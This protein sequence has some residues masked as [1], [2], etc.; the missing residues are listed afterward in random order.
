MTNKKEVNT[1][2]GSYIDGK[3][4]IGGDYVGEDKYQVTINM[5]SD[6]TLTSILGNLLPSQ[7]KAPNKQEIFKH[8]IEP[9]FFK[10]E[11]VHKDYTMML[12]E[13]KRQIN[14]NNIDQQSLID[15]VEARMIIFESER[16]YLK[17]IG[18]ETG[19]VSNKIISDPEFKEYEKLIFQFGNEVIAYFTTEC[20]AN[21]VDPTSISS[22]YGVLERLLKEPLH[23]NIGPFQHWVHDIYKELPNKWERITQTYLTLR[24]TSLI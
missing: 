24:G 10:L 14:E 6:T 7:K 2:G 8:H 15:W 11:Q 16:T 21:I 23:K 9:T 12:L 5:V 19:E 17:N 18:F 3:A 22:P 20:P 4:T 1:D 13:L